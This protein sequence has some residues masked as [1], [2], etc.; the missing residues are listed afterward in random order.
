MTEEKNYINEILS[1]GVELL[2]SP[3]LKFPRELSNEDRIQ[4]FQRMIKYFET[5]EEYLKCAALEKPLYKYVIKQK[6][7]HH[8]KQ[9]YARIKNAISSSDAS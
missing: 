7:E 1:E 6:H 5:Q 8:G 9:K 3:K 2:I 4:L